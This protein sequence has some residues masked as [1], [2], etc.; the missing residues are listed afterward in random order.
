MRI[1]AQSHA[2]KSFLMVSLYLLF[3]SYP[4]AVE[5]SHSLSHWTMTFITL[6]MLITCFNYSHSVMNSHIS[7]RTLES[8]YININV[9]FWFAV[10]VSGFSYMLESQQNHWMC[11]SLLASFLGF[12]IQFF[13]RNIFQL[14]DAYDVHHTKWF[15]KFGGIRKRNSYTGITMYIN[16]KFSFMGIHLSLVQII[17]WFMC[18]VNRDIIPL[19]M[20]VVIFQVCRF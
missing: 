3:F 9:F 19:Y 11:L 14:I 8:I 5:L 18:T 20:H 15:R 2:V 13:L 16:G 12:F 17:W 7:S 10:L 6:V 4:V 1:F